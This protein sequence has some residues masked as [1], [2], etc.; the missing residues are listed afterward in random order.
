M[1]LT[2]KSALITGANQGLGYE[3]AKQF[4]EH[5][6]NVMLCARNASLLEQ[7]KTELSKLAK[8]NRV[9]AIACDISNRKQVESL[10]KATVDA[11]GSIDTL[12]ANAGVYGPKGAIEEVDWDEW[13]DAIDINLKGTVYIARTVVPYMKKQKRGNIIFISGGGATKPLPNLSAYAVSKAGVVR[14]AE[15]L[16][17][18]KK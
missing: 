17:E 11:F 10:V 2:G 6:A 13:V 8:S 9:M 15:T 14:F 18:L 3:I 7:A 5:G 12:V 16:A 4:I 1:T